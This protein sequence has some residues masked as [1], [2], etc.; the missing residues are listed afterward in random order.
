LE[1]G[2]LTERTKAL[3]AVLGDISA[4][5]EDKK[6]ATSELLSMGDKKDNPVSGITNFVKPDLPAPGRAAVPETVAPPPI[7]GPGARS[8]EFRS[9]PDPAVEEQKRKRMNKIYFHGTKYE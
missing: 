4:S 7:R 5:P 3:T 9:G 6:A 2:L 1:R 8:M